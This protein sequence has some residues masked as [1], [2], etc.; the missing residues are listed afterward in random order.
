VQI[1]VILIA[2]GGGFLL[3]GNR[4]IEEVRSLLWSLAALSFCLGVGIGGFRGGVLRPFA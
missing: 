3:V 4:A 2:L 1:G